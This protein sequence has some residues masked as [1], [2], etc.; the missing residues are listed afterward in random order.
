MGYARAETLAGRWWVGHRWADLRVSTNKQVVEKAGSWRLKKIKKTVCVDHF[1]STTNLHREKP[2]AWNIG[3]RISMINECAVKNYHI[4]GTPGMR[5]G[6]W[7]QGIGAVVATWQGCAERTDF[8][9]F[10]E[11]KLGDLET[12][13]AP[14]APIDHGALGRVC[15]SAA[16]SV[17]LTETAIPGL[18]WRTSDCP[19]GACGEEVKIFT[20]S[21]EVR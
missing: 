2:V 18:P 19:G 14:H 13:A 16:A 4:A 9:A 21:A 8:F 5:M 11:E 17:C 1:S 10:M 15:R 7:D 20:S 3:D 12:K 6:I